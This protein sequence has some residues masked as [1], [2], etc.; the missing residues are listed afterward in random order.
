MAI[1][2]ALQ[3]DTDNPVPCDLPAC[4]TCGGS[5]CSCDAI[6]KDCTPAPTKSPLM[7]REPVG[8]C[9][10]VQETSGAKFFDTVANGLVWPAV[11]YSITVEVAD[12]S[13]YAVGQ[14]VYVC[15]GYGWLKVSAVRTSSGAISLLNEGSKKNVAPGTQT[16]VPVN[17]APGP[18]P[19]PDTKYADLKDDIEDAVEDEVERQVN[20]K[21][22]PAPTFPLAKVSV[23][24]SGRIPLWNRDNGCNEGAKDTTLGEQ[25]VRKTSEG[26]LASIRHLGCD[27]ESVRIDK[28]DP[29]AASHG[30]MLGV[31]PV[32]YCGTDDPPEPRKIHPEQVT[33]EDTPAESFGLLGYRTETV[34]CSGG[35]VLKKIWQRLRKLF[36]HSGLFFDPV[37]DDDTLRIIVANKNGEIYK[38]APL[39]LGDGQVLAGDG[40][41]GVKIVNVLDIVPPSVVA[42]AGEPPTLISGAGNFSGTT[43]PNTEQA[44]PDCATHA[45]VSCRLVNANNS[46]SEMI[47][48]GVSRLKAGSATSNPG[49]VDTVAWIPLATPTSSFTVTIST[50]AGSPPTAWNIKLIGYQCNRP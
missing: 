38:F 30:D 14:C 28:L 33:E 8:Q 10:D 2:E 39:T 6:S 32:D 24:E 5:D 13:K 49:T 40:G 3:G 43:T 47:L 22:D 45:I 27:S 17:I 50:A 9:E 12:A 7:F 15:G 20:A 4:G 19:K 31:T 44:A 35:D 36:F 42:G 1:E 26:Y 48:A 16:T 34:S 18:C 23:L 37:V 41:G 29:P 21:I 25:Q 46:E 11:G